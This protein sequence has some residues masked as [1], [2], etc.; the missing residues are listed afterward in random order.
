MRSEGLTNIIKANKN[1]KH[2]KASDLKGNDHKFFDLSTYCPLLESLILD[3]TYDEIEIF[4]KG[5]RNLKNLR[6]EYC[7]ESDE[8]EDMDKLLQ[9]LGSNNPLLETLQLN[10]NQQ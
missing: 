10:A 7:F 3:I 2:Y 6:I 5:C 9:C 4:T 1:L 8:D